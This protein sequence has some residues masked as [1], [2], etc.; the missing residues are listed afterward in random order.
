[1]AEA[2]EV[3]AGEAQSSAGFRQD[4]VRVFNTEFRRLY[5][6]L[7]RLSGDPELAADVAQDAF[8]RLYQRGALPD[9]TPAWLLTVAMN[10]FRNA[11]V[12]RSRRHRLLTPS[13][14]ERAV[15]DPPRQPDEQLASDETQRQVRAALERLSERSRRLLLLRAEGYSYRELASV[16]QLNEH[17]VGVLLARAK[18]DFRAAC[19]G[20]DAP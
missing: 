10:L 14:M 5:R 12:M 3:S 8:V 18:A 7:D 1:V 9:E 13:R 17:S 16:L 11:Q 4:F 19:E 2:P 6:Y 15:A 20:I